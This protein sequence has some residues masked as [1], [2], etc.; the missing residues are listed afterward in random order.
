MIE[1]CKAMRELAGGNFDV[2]LLASGARTNS[3]RWR[4][5]GRVQ[6]AGGCQGRA[7]CR[8]H[9]AQNRASSAARRTELIRFA[10]EFETAVV[11]SSPTFRR[12]PCNWNRRRER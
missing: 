10:D 4:G 5:G 11:R 12:P 7:R 9:D 6:G 3:A 2:V 1:M 8:G